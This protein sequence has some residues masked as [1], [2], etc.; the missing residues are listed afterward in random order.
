MG[1]REDKKFLEKT[2]RKH[3]VRTVKCRILLDSRCKDGVKILPQC[4]DR[5]GSVALK[6]FNLYNLWTAKE[7]KQKENVIE[8]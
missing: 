4:F 5:L 3:K 2:A 8:T 6:N 1:I 7:A